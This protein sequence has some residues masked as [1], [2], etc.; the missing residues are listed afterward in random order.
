MGRRD[1]EEKCPPTKK[2]GQL[3]FTTYHGT[4]TSDGFGSVSADAALRERFAR[5]R[6]HYRDAHR[7]LWESRRA[8]AYPN[9]CAE[10]RVAGEGED[11]AFGWRGIFERGSAMRLDE[12]TSFPT[13]HGV[14]RCGVNRKTRTRWEKLLPSKARDAGRALDL[15]A[16][17]GH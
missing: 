13:K 14:G 11:S 5:R 8:R 3:L 10:Q 17:G 7:A 4:F 2:I 15:R 9:G 12:G 6:I 16:G 1:D